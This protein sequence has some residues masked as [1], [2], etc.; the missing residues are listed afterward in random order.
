MTA[1][2]KVWDYRNL[3]VNLVLRNLRAR[4]KK[5]ILGW[6]WSLINPA[7]TLGIYTIVFGLFL[8]GEAPALGNGRDGIFALWLFAALVGWGAFNGGITTV[9]SSFLDSGHL[10]TR[11]YFPPECPVIAGTLTVSIQ[12][13][14]E[15]AILVVFM[16]VLGN[17]GWTTIVVIPVMVLLTLLSF[18]VGL[19]VSLGN[20]RF[21]DINYLV[22]IALQIAFY[23]T[24]I[25]YRLDQL[26]EKVSWMKTLLGF[27][28]MTHFVTAT[29]DVT[30]LLTMPTLLNWA[31]MVG[32]TAAVVGF[33][34]WLFS[35]KAP[36]YIE[37]I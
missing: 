19:M 2:A 23:A 4:Y 20:V 13:A 8:S 34:W 31:V 25:V 17:L 21:R 24:P 16:A 33:G 15:T 22:G 6:G 11:T 30:Y 28:P 29:R 1:P 7:V 37:E 32:S 18:G 14:I 9:M 10:L 36:R 27:N 35:R 26:P 3:I 5:S 12:T